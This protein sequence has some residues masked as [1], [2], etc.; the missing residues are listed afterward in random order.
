MDK[1]TPKTP[2]NK[3]DDTW[4]IDPSDVQRHARRM[5]ERD[6]PDPLRRIARYAALAVVIAAIGAA[7]WNRET[8]LGITVDTSALTSL[9]KGGSPTSPGA[10]AE[11]G[12]EGAA[13]V[14][15]AAVVGTKVSTSIDAEPA[16]TAAP[17]PS[18]DAAPTRTD[19]PGAEPVAAISEPRLEPPAAAPTP[20]AVPEPP[21]PPPEPEHF[22]FGLERV[23]V[24]E[25]QPSAAVLI[26]RLGDRRR[27]SSVTWWTEE[28]TAKAG[29]DYVNLGVQTERFA[30]GEQNRT[31]HVP[32]VGDH[33]AEGAENFFV[34][35]RTRTG[36]GDDIPTTRVE[37]VIN[38]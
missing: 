17:P 38:D 15:A 30:A 6:R 20:V 19:A 7:Y 36:N 28:G 13:S 10:S 31:I 34:V 35:A 12:R 14:E 23:T 33:N 2:P 8:L 27:A 11:D 32:I 5:Q 3:R 25:S 29:S 37:V 22:E 18:A 24:F 4:V 1:R 9:F 16:E 21:A 26:L